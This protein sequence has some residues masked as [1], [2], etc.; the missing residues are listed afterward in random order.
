MH[1]RKQALALARQLRT[2]PPSRVKDDPFFSRKVQRHIEICPFCATDLKEETDTFRDL[3][4]KLDRE[5]SLGREDAGIRSGQVRALD[6]GLS[7]WRGDFFYTPPEVMVLETG[8]GDIV[9][10]AQVW[11]DTALAGPGD[12]VVP[13]DAGIPGFGGFFIE[14]WNIYTLDRR[15]LASC[16]GTLDPRVIQDIFRMKDTPD[17]LPE[18]ALRPMPL[19]ENDPRIYFREL[20]IETSYTFASMAAGELAAAMEQSRFP[21]IQTDDLVAVLREKVPG[22]SWD[23]TPRSAEECFALLRFP[24]ETL[25]RAAADRDRDSI[26]ANYFCMEKEGITGAVPVECMILHASTSPPGYTVSGQ[27]PGL[28]GDVR[29]Q[30]FQC[31]IKN[32]IGQILFPGRFAWEPK[33]NNFMAVFDRPLEDAE[34]IVVFIVHTRIPEAE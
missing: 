24:S 8:P 4:A 20:E 13:A 21:G 6:P 18:Y 26:T 12:L 9:Q 32:S 7:C 2:C 16:L 27:I 3:A 29:E 33:D 11:Q 17:Y 23:W 19:K 5:F 22:I 1:T 31:F 14:T 15:F 34:A 25:A 30:D 10:V 28:P